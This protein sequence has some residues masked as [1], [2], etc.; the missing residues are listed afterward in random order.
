[1]SLLLDNK[2]GLRPLSPLAQFPYFVQVVHRGTQ[3]AVK[4]IP[5]RSFAEAERV[6][7]GVLINLNKKTYRTSIRVN[8][9]CVR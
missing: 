4:S 1:M 7:Q 9:D 8:P 6:E 5:V 3:K 2:G